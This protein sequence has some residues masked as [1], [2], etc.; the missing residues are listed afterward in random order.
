M[1]SPLRSLLESVPPLPVD[2][3]LSEVTDRFQQG[4]FERMLSLAVVDEANKPVG[5]ISRHAL[6]ELLLNKY[7][8]DLFGKRPIRFFMNTTP[9]IVALSEAPTQ[10]ISTVTSQ[11]RIPIVE[12]FI[13]TEADGTYAGLGSVADVLKMV[14]QRLGQRNQALAKANQ[15]IK[16]SQAHLIQSEKMAALGQMVAGVAHEINTPLGYVG[17]N[18]QMAQEMLVQI[19]DLIQEYEQLFDGLVNQTAAPQE[20]EAHIQSIAAMR[21]DFNVVADLADLGELFQD[22]RFGLKQIGEIVQ[23]LK[24][25]A[26][27]DRASTDRVNLIENIETALTVGQHHLKN[28]VTI[29]KRFEPIP[30]VPCAPSQINQVLLNIFTNAAHAITHDR[31]RLLIRTYV[32]GAF[33]CISIEDNGSGI[34]EE[35]VSRIFEPFYTTKKVGEGT[36]LGLSISYRIIKDHGGDIRLATKLG[37]GTRFE[38]SLPID[39]PDATDSANDM[40]ERGTVADAQPSAGMRSPHHDDLPVNTTLVGSA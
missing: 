20:I 40:N 6:M 2:L 21:A 15:E 26:R 14:E 5:L 3:P 29:E 32:R 36:G 19:Q 11:I 17:N 38:I 18:V 1:S 7:S 31:G 24:N 13:F 34:P 30:E 25:F 39:G 12:D 23:S 35:H 9:V 33:A 10:V 27:V 16:A 28:K 4:G 37:V 8:R 22:T